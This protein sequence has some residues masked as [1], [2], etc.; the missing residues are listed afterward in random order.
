MT[1]ARWTQ[2]KQVRVRFAERLRPVEIRRDRE[3]EFEGMARRML[4]IQADVWRMEGSQSGERHKG[5]KTERWWRWCVERTV[6][7][8]KN[9]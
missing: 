7:D 1:A 2:M 8:L 6:E 3:G 4:G 5:W 9:T